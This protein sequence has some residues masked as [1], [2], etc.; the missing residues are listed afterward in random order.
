MKIAQV[1]PFEMDIEGRRA[2]SL[3]AGERARKPLPI[4]PFEKSPAFGQDY[5][6]VASR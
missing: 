4:H 1:E 6:S 2:E 5:V 3:R